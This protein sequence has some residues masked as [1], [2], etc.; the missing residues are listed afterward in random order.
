MNHIMIAGNLVADPE[1]RYTPSGTKVTT[2]RVA[3]NNRRG[4]QEE[5]LFWR[6]T[7]WGENLD[8]MISYLKKGSSVMVMGDMSK[9][10]IY[11]DRSGQPQISLNMTGYN[12][13]FSPFGRGNAQSGDGQQQSGMSSQGS[14]DPFAGMDNNDY[15]QVMQGQ[16]QS[17]SGSSSFSDDEIP[18]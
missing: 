18:F 6:V 1:A 9:P 11:T 5:T 4:K 13:S 15:S 14:S 3:V 12:I 2:V 7:F 10:E 17:N 8:K 16:G